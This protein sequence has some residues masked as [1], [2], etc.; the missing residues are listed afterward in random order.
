[1]EGSQVSTIEGVIDALPVL[2]P[3]TPGTLINVDFNTGTYQR[4]VEIARTMTKL[5]VKNNYNAPVRVQLFCVV[6]RGETSITPVS[7]L[8]EGLADIGT[9]I[10]KTTPMVYPSDSSQFKDLY[11]VIRKSSKTLVAG[12][13]LSIRYSGGSFMFDPAFVDLHTLQYQPRFRSHLYLIRVEG[14]LGHD[15][16]VSE[17]GYVGC[18]S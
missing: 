10:N 17:Q 3:S 7:A 16:S 9:G 18:R 11:V 15:T 8:S 12:Q 1:M 6:P 4:K 13:T 5:T 2:D 14:V